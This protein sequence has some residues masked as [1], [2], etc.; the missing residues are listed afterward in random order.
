MPATPAPAGLPEDLTLGIRELDE[1]HRTLF[2][3]LDRILAVSR[4]P[5]RQLDDDGTNAV[6]DIMTDLKDAAL[7]HFDQEE[8]LMG[9]RD[10]PGLD[11]QQ[12]AHERFLVDLVRIEADLMNGTA[13]PPVRLHADLADQLAAHVRVMDRELVQFLNKSEK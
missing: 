5:Y 8:T 13:V 3:V 11:D 1:Q 10:Y 12:E 7:Q 2:T 9:Q 4:D 6:L